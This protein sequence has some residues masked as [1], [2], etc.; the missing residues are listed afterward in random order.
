MQSERERI[1]LFWSLNLPE[2]KSAGG[3]SYRNVK[4]QKKKQRNKTLMEV[5]G[6]ESVVLAA[7][8]EKL[9]QCLNCGMKFSELSCLCCARQVV[10]AVHTR[11]LK[12]L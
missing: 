2:G 3:F 5:A 10:C 9:G 8:V 7:K 1:C 11:T 4:K 6:Q 12:C